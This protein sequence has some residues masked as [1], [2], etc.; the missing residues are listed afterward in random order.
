MSFKPSRLRNCKN[1]S[2][3]SE[4]WSGHLMGVCEL[5]YFLSLDKFQYLDC[6]K[7]WSLMASL[8]FLPPFASIRFLSL[9][10]Y[11]PHCCEYA[12]FLI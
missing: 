9:G 11:K 3:T 1:S 7:Q 4:N 2:K 8:A 12:L 6:H 10:Q 5:L